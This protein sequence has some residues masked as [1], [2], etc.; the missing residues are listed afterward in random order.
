MNGHD[1]FAALP[2]AALTQPWLQRLD[3]LASRLIRH[4]ACNTPPS[5]QPRL[6][7]EWLADMAARGGR[8]SRL[9]LAVGCWWA[10]SV[11]AHECAVSGVATALDANKTAT[12]YASHG[13]GFVSGRT[14]ALILIACL[15]LALIYVLAVGL[16]N[17]REAALYDP[18]LMGFQQEIPDRGP[19]P[20]P[21]PVRFAP[22]HIDVVEPQIPLDVPRDAGPQD[23]T[24][25]RTRDT[26]RA[27]PAKVDRIIGGPG[28]G[29][30]NTAD[31]YPDAS[32]RLGEK[33]AAGV[34]VCVDANGR[35]TSQPAITQSSGSARL[36]EGALTLARA[37]SGH[38]RATTEDG[39]AVSSCFPFRIRFEFRD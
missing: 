24:S 15:H 6:E 38:Y 1:I 11:I 31:Y 16:G 14:I 7:E 33:G 18:M 34:Q 27:A 26:V 39:R 23:L 2:A 30:P 28:K 36:D 5:L 37:G 9:R 25:E 13:P 29:F 32:R 22:T 12:A 35:L 3:R 19:P 21:L 8:V 17:R 10:A 4:A 20:P